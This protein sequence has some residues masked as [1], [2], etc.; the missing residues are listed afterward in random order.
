MRQRVMVVVLCLLVTE[1][2]ATYLICESKYG[3]VM[4]LMAFQTHN[5]CVF[6]QNAPFASFGVICLILTFPSYSGSM[7]LR[8]NRTLCVACYVCII[9]PWCMC[10]RHGCKSWSSPLPS[11]AY[12]RAFEGYC[13]RWLLFSSKP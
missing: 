4:F 1:L 5:S 13:R 12:L 8:I 10:F 11:S 2:I 7:I 6:C 9:S 3:V